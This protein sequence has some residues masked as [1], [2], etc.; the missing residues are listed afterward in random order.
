MSSLV[1]FSSKQVQSASLGSPFHDVC[2]MVQYITAHICI[3]VSATQKMSAP[4]KWLYPDQ[5]FLTSPGAAS[6]MLSDFMD[7]YHGKSVVN[8][9]WRVLPLV[10]CP[11][12]WS[13]VPEMYL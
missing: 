4:A 5:E 7:S 12:C 3:R 6:I 9:T 13:I 1:A 10:Q 8:R 11:L 2:T